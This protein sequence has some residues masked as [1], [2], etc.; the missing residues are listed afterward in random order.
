M[1]SVLHRWSIH[2]LF[3]QILGRWVGWVPSGGGVLLVLARILIKVRRIH[4]GSRR[5]RVV[6]TSAHVRRIR[7]SHL[8]VVVVGRRDATPALI[9]V[10]S[11]LPVRTHHVHWVAPLRRGVLEGVPTALRS[12]VWPVVASWPILVIIVV[13]EGIGIKLLSLVIILILYL[14][15]GKVF[16]VC[17]SDTF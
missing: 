3:I 15:I 9:A 11:V 13:G 10:D 12:I 5:G 16:L 1:L 6:R 14:V 8:V 2:V 17:L 7:R 4:L